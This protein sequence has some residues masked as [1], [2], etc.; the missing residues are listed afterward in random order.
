MFMACD[1]TPEETARSGD[2]EPETGDCRTEGR[3]G[4]PEEQLGASGGVSEGKPGGQRPCEP[5]C[6][7]PGGGAWLSQALI[8]QLYVAIGES[9]ERRK[10]R[11]HYPLWILTTRC[12]PDAGHSL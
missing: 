8:L 4:E 7:S 11:V 3:S 10:R 9:N 6:H 1:I 2:G 5:P 12:E